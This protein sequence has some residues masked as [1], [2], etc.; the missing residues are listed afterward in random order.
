MP[1]VILSVQGGNTVA[2]S[3]V[4]AEVGRPGEV[5]EGLRSHSALGAEGLLEAGVDEALMRRRFV[6]GPSPELMQICRK[7]GTARSLRTG[8]F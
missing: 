6:R 4:P 3:R 5:E 7:T 8:L 2:G 1:Q